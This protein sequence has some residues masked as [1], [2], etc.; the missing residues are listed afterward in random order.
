MQHRLYSLALVSMLAITSFL[1]PITGAAQATRSKKASSNAKSTAKP[2]TPSG[3][4]KTTFT[5]SVDQNYCDVSLPYSYLSSKKGLDL[6]VAS[7]GAWSAVLENDWS[8][9]VHTSAP[10]SPP[11]VPTFDSG[12]TSYQ[13]PIGKE[14]P[15][16]RDPLDANGHLDDN[17]LPIL[18]DPAKEF[19]SGTFDAQR[20]LVRTLFGPNPFQVAC[21]YPYLKYPKA[22]VSTQLLH[23]GPDGSSVPLLTKGAG[24]AFSLNGPDAPDYYLINIVRWEDAAAPKGANQ[25][26][27]FFQA[28]SDN[29]YLLN[30]SDAQDRR[31]DISQWFHKIT[32]AMESDTLRI[33]GN[34]KVM[35]LGIHL[36]P[37]PVLGKSGVPNPNA[38]TGPATE[39]AWFDDVTVKYTFQASKATSIPMQDLGAALQIVLSN[40]GLSTGGAAAPAPVNPGALIEVPSTITSKLDQLEAAIS[41]FNGLGFES[42]DY[43][44]HQQDPAALTSLPQQRNYGTGA[45]ATLLEVSTG[46]VSWNLEVDSQI[47]KLAASNDAAIASIDEKIK[48]Q[49]TPDLETKRSNLQASNSTAISAILQDL[50]AINSLQSALSAKPVLST[51]QGR[52]AAG[53][54]TNLTSLP[55]TL[56]SNWNATFT[57]STLSS[58]WSPTAGVY[59][60]TTPVPLLPDHSQDT[61][62]QSNRDMGSV[63]P[64]TTTATTNVAPAASSPVC[65]VA[66]A[67]GSTSQA[68]CPEQPA[69]VLDEGRSHWD[70][71]VVVPLMGFK[72]VTFQSGTAQSG[73]TPSTPNVITS[74]TVTR[75]N[76]YGVFDL[77]LIKEDLVSPPYVGIPHV[78]VGLP[79]AGKVF[80]KP[81]FAV[82][83]TI[84]FSKA[85]AK[86]PFL[87]KIPVINSLAQSDLPLS[88]RPIFG[89]VYNKEFPAAATGSTQPYR[90]LK[91]QW[92]IELS[93]SSIKNAV[94]TFSKGSGSGTGSTPK[95]TTPSTVPSTN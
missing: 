88:V 35:F 44:L 62:D 80:D 78:V 51:Y 79:F 36:A 55:A 63:T 11:F 53:L 29:W 23:R 48:T 75:E 70:V 1:A 24:F 73:S 5:L 59:D 13:V 33:I 61:V 28:A 4:S 31:Q 90:S 12:I 27:P 94:Q 71:S 67:T 42:I 2:A 57:S 56:A 52:Y 76:A 39:Q 60:L 38:S 69:S 86:I 83:E 74:K 45:E 66:V 82:G 30:Y 92:A 40:L 16:P 20:L 10:A 3:G 72:D 89:W 46:K 64:S 17:G 58:K 15:T 18:A 47:R 91:P 68:A 21:A 41:A 50:A 34:K 65:T 14:K 7:T 9:F 77:F 32:P 49:S 95:T 87:T 37:L 22:D 26:S 8:T 43:F 93:F 81:Y 85:I 6:N 84:N 54:L 25:N 19:T